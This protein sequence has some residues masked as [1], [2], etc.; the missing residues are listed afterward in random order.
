MT[1][2]LLDR[3]KRAHLEFEG[4]ELASVT[5][6]PNGQKA[7]WT[8]LKVYVASTKQIVAQTLGL[9]D[10]DGETTRSDAEVVD[11]LEKLPNVFGF[12]FLAK[13]LYK[14]LSLDFSERL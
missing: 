13:E 9:S 12:G 14:K 8:E 2:F 4:D 5:S 10:F 7:R 3:K 1:K 11:S 6:N